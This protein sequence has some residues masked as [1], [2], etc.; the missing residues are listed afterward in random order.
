MQYY[1][2]AIVKQNTAPQ[3]SINII[4]FRLNPAIMQRINTV[5]FSSCT[6]GSKI[7]VYTDHIEGE[8]APQ[9]AST[10]AHYSFL[11]SQKSSYW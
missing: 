5:K 2:K 10:A 4:K 9:L 8:E 7:W 6:K 1:K 11:M 3:C